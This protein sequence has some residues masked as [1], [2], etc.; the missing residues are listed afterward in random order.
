MKNILTSEV[1]KK[2]SGCQL[3]MLLK[4]FSSTTATRR[5][6]IAVAMT[7]A[8]KKDSGCQ[9]LMLLIGLMPLALELE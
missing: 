8:G 4:R 7:R 2:D 9:L 6:F 1:P 5:M 3:L